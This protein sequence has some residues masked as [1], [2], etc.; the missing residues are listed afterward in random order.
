MKIKKI[1]SIGALALVVA[2]STSI[3]ASA[4]ERPSNEKIKS[5][6]INMFLT[7]KDPVNYSVNKNT[8]VGNVINITK[9]QDDVNKYGFGTGSYSTLNEALGLIDS[10]KTVAYNAKKIVVT[11]SAEN[12]LDELLLQTR[13]LMGVLRQIENTNGDAKVNIENDIKA[14]VK[15]SNSTLDVAFGKNID[16]RITMSIT[17]GNQIVLQLNSGNAY[18][19]NNSLGTNAD[20]LETYAEALKLFL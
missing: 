19:I 18:T 20:K 8:T 17:Q 15:G 3:G 16:G 14:L 1:V 4:A 10:N 2:C 9:L 12:K 6:M 13:N 5:D 7:G 11:L